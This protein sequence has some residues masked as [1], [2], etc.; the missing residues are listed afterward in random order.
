M[1]SKQW[2]QHVSGMGEKWEV[3]DDEDKSWWVTT[4]GQRHIAYR[5]PKSEYRL[6]EPPERWEDV[7]G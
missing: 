6:C 5:L 7:T 1:G 4:L 2:V 3:K